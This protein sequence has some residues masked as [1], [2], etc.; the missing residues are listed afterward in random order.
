MYLL[1][2]NVSSM[3]LTQFATNCLITTNRMPATIIWFMSSSNFI[4]SY[5]SVVSFVPDCSINFLG[6]I[7][8]S[9]NF[10]FSRPEHPL[11]TLSI[12]LPPEASFHSCKVSSFSKLLMLTT[13]WT[14]G[15]NYKRNWTET[16][17]MV[18]PCSE[19]GRR[20]I[21]QNSI[22]VNAETKESTRKTEEK[23]DGR[24]KEG[25]ER[26]KPKGRPVGR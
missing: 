6:T 17:Y 12:S 22:E 5:S 13:K 20:K 23:R 10:T 7:K 21:T 3:N 18:R 14:R 1:S 24:Y 11:G 8:T 16:A 26:K 9:H 4:Y 19:N 15:N 2:A 25:H